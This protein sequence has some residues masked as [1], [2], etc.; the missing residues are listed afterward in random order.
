MFNRELKER[1]AIL[2]TIVE[3]L[4]SLLIKKEVITKGQMQ[5]ELL[6]KAEEYEDEIE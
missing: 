6:K 4:L 1:V 3:A 5:I 2:E